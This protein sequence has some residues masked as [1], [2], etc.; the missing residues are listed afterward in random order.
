MNGTMRITSQLH[1]CNQLGQNDVIFV[2]LILAELK[3]V[4]AMH[5]RSIGT[6]ITKKYVK[7]PD[8]RVSV[9]FYLKQR[10]AYFN[11]NAA[12]DAKIICVMQYRAI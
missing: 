9:I 11:L 1:R 7:Y 6:T 2:K 8:A 10:V 5:K 12:N 3:G 4:N